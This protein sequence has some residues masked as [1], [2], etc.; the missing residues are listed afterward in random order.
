MRHAFAHPE[1]LFALAALPVVGLLSAYARQRGRRALLQIGGLVQGT[2]L[3]ARTARRWRGWCVSLG[4]TCLALGMAGPQWGRDWSQSAAPGRDLVVVLD[5][6]WSMFAQQPARIER[7]R[8]ALRDLAR[9]LRVQGGHRVALVVFAGKARLACPLTHDLDHFAE[10]VGD[11]DLT[12]PDPELVGGTHGTRI[13]AA[14]ERA[15]E[16]HDGPNPD[17]RD[18]V[19]LSDGDDP[20]RDG[21]WRAGANRCRAEKVAVQVVGF[22]DP[23]QAYPI[24]QG[25]KRWLTY[26]GAPVQTRLEEAPLRDI[27]RITGGTYT[28]AGNRDVALGEFYL[29]HA[30]KAQRDSADALP[31]QRQRYAWFLGPAFFLLTVPLLVPDR[32]RGGFGRY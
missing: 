26:N 6:S 3:A 15:L 16:A 17:A 11:I 29:D 5:E 12:A 23:D 31:V 32:R 10:V 18:V 4:M 9:A 25:E 13:G 28:A 21:E 30:G 27:A 14:L 24:P 8:D 2:V 1:L 7:A 22:G 20:A 19:L